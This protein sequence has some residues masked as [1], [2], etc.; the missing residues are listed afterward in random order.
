MYQLT[1]CN[2][3]EKRPDY[4]RDP[5]RATKDYRR[6]DTMLSQIDLPRGGVPS[7]LDPLSAAARAIPTMNDI[8]PAKKMTVAQARMQ[9]RTSL[10]STTS[11][12][13]IPQEPALAQILNIQGDDPTVVS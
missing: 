12:L 6:S 11:M 7:D 2:Q 1:V 4:I 3:S 5:P 13:S 8:A 10:T 9:T